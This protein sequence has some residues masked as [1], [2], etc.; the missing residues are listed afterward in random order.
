MINEQFLS[1][2][3]DKQ[4]EMG[5][6]WL[7]ASEINNFWFDPET[8]TLFKYFK[9]SNEVYI[10]SPCSN[11]NDIIPIQ[12]EYNITLQ[13]DHIG[14]GVWFADDTMDITVGNKNPLRAICEVYILMNINKERNV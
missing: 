8:G 13:S 11:P 7:Q 6:A 14:N 2:C 9:N 3:T 10:F 5:V 1:G 4:I 12:I